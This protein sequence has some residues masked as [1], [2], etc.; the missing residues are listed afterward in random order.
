[1]FKIIHLSPVEYTFFGLRAVPR[2]FF[3][4]VSGIR[5]R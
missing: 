2:R 1:M 4:T 3:R 5:D